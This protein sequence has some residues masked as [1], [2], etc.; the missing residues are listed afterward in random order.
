MSVCVRPV[1]QTKKKNMKPDLKITH[2][3]IINKVLLQ[4]LYCTP[5]LKWKA[6]A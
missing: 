4:K 1:C 3:M 2:D 6:R 5:K